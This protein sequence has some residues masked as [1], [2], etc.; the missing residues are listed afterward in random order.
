MKKI[1]IR[2][3]PRVD[4]W[5]NYALV[6]AIKDGIEKHGHEVKICDL[7]KDYQQP[8][9]AF[10][11][12]EVPH[13]KDIQDMITRADELIFVF[14]I[15]NMDCPAIMKNFLDVNLWQGFG[16]KTGADGKT[17]PLLK[18]KTARIIATAWGPSILYYPIWF[19]S[20]N[21]WR[22]GFS[23]IKNRSTTILGYVKTTTDTKRQKFIEKVVKL[24]SK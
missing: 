18:S 21:L 4:T 22:F 6:T 15:W 23:W 7:Y 10:N 19:I 9:L 24:C 3:H 5:Y 20:W 17:I 12:D 1:I 8:F 2:A 13:K 11:H 16:Y 14:P